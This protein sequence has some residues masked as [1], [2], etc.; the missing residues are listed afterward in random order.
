MG[1]KIAEWAAEHLVAAIGTTV[2]AAFDAGYT[3]LPQDEQAA[4]SA[5]D[6]A[7]ASDDG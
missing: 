6:K 3:P 4:P 5:E 1:R 2:G 7:P